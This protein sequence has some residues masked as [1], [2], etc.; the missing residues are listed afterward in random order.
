MITINKVL[1]KLPI[2]LVHECSTSLMTKK[3]D[4]ERAVLI[5]FYKETPR[6]S[7]HE[8][9]KEFDVHVTVDRS[10]PMQATYVKA[11]KVTEKLKEVGK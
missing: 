8:L 11:Y 9:Y 3:N 7:L 1:S 10:P 4:G 5:A 6:G 2:E